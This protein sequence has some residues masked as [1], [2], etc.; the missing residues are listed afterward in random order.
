ME[1]QRQTE[2]ARLENSS[3]V[4]SRSSKKKLTSYK[5]C[6][7][8]LLTADRASERASWSCFCS[9]NCRPRDFCRVFYQESQG[10]VEKDDLTNYPRLCVFLKQT[11]TVCPLKAPI[12]NEIHFFSLRFVRKMS[13]EHLISTGTH[14]SAERTFPPIEFLDEQG[15]K[16]G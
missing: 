4:R 10:G 11:A 3:L 15:S 14:H 16:L 1:G 7:S 8:C 12:P 2:R 13:C 5:E 6:C 9:T